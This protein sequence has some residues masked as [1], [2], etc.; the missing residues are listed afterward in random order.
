M[1]KEPEEISVRLQVYGVLDHS[2]SS[3][4]CNCRYIQ[5]NSNAKKMEHG[6]DESSRF[7]YTHPEQMLGFSHLGTD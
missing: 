4:C 1:A 6:V 2:S 5:L 3:Y 7:I